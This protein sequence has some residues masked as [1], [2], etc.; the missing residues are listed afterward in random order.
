MFCHSDV[1][2]SERGVNYAVRLVVHRAVTTAANA[3]YT[4]YVGCAK[5][6]GHLVPVQITQLGW[7]DPTLLP[8][9]T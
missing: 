4:W 2:S 8:P 7:R 3:N 6:N 5:R 9:N 1:V